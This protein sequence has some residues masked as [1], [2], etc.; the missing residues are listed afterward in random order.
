LV[1]K[2][3]DASKDAVKLGIGMTAT[4]AAPVLWVGCLR[5]RESKPEAMEKL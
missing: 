3:S 4:L 5:S 2:R 1:I